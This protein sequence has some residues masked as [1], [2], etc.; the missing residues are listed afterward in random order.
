MSS[1]KIFNAGTLATEVENYYKNNSFSQYT[2]LN[3]SYGEIVFSYMLLR[4]IYKNW[5]CFDLYDKKHQ[6]VAEIQITDNYYKTQALEHDVIF[7]FYTPGGKTFKLKNLPT[8]APTVSG[9]VWRDSE[10]YL[11]IS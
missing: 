7:N 6:K 5:R 11:R 10:G 2:L 8:N 3:G 1:Q 9:A 4:L